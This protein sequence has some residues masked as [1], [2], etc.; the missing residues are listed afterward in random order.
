MLVSVQWLPASVTVSLAMALQA[1]EPQRKTIR[2]ERVLISPCGAFVSTTAGLSEVAGCTVG[3]VGVATG[4]V[5]VSGVGVVAG[6][7]TVTW[8]VAE[9]DGLYRVSVEPE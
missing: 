1:L 9:M 5:D 6:L 3:G 4:P 8:A 7:L 2:S